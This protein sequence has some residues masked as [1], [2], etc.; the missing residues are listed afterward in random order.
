VSR[1]CRVAS[2]RPHRLAQLTIASPLNRDCQKSPPKS[3]PFLDRIA[4]PQ[5][6]NPRFRGDLFFLPQ[7]ELECRLNLKRLKHSGCGNAFSTSLC[8]MSEVPHAIFD[9]VQSL[10]EWILSR[11]H[12]QRLVRGIYSLLFL[13]KSACSQPMERRG[14]QEVFGIHSGS[15]PALW[16]TRANSYD[17]PQPKIR[18]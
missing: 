15:R 12:R 14:D 16:D 13:F 2:D 7:A 17:Q 6:S 1:K 18:L 3:A 5:M 8:G 9:R 4:S 11:A 10:P